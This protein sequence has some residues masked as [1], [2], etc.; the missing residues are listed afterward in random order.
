MG[1]RQSP[2]Q[3]T[4][5][6]TPAVTSQ[7]HPLSHNQGLLQ[8]Q[9]LIGNKAV[10]RLLAEN[11]DEK[12]NVRKFTQEEMQWISEVWDLPEIQLMFQAY[13]HVPGPILHRVKDRGG[14]DGS[15]L[16]ADIWIADKTYETCSNYTIDP[17][18]PVKT[19]NADEFKGTLLHEMLHY[20]ENQTKAVDPSSVATPGKM[21]DMLTNPTNYRK[22][23]Y[24]YGW[25]VHPKSNL[26]LHL[27]LEETSNFMREEA[28]VDTEGESWL[29]QVKRGHHYESS[30]MAISGDSVSP[31]E[32][33]AE[34]MSLYLT[35]PE[36]RAKLKKDF[37]QRY[38]MIE[39]YFQRALPAEIQK[40]QQAE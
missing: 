3:R 11:E 4:K 7:P 39:G 35:S 26:L 23:P 5:T 13:D 19:S 17:S 22:K 36:S 15:A 1:F 6:Q 10:Q 37:P 9:T 27:D 31:E 24:A 16:D 30:P 14:A 32:D 38:S 29:S 28:Y 40:K 8:L 18:K 12:D 2:V 33:L 21:I 34:T 25:F 20:F